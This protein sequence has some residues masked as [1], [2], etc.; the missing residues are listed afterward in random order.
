MALPRLTAPIILAPLAMAGLIV[1]GLRRRQQ[2][3]LGRQKRTALAAT[4][5]W[6]NE[7][8]RVTSP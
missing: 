2:R 5:A 7:G 1:Y 3:N 4:A 8:G 6:E